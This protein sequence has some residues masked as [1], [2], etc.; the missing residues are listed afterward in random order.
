MKL[1][2]S[3][4]HNYTGGTPCW[5]HASWTAL[6]QRARRPAWLLG[7][8]TGLLTYPARL[9]PDQTHHCSRWH[10]YSLPKT[11]LTYINRSSMRKPCSKCTDRFSCNCSICFLCTGAKTLA[12]LQYAHSEVHRYIVHHP[13]LLLESESALDTFCRFLL[14]FCA[15]CRAKPPF[16]DASLASSCP[17]I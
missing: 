1:T 8:L 15:M 6:S 10:C 14:P 9:W 3:A 4:G 7:T 17:A 16:K 5:R 2:G 13:W 11:N 12:T